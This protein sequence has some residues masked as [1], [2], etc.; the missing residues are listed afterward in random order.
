MKKV[1]K[2]I[3]RI[4]IFS[5]LRVAFVKKKEKFLKQTSD[6]LQVY[7]LIAGCE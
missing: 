7:K 6:K 1:R 5:I 4:A 3:K 2:G